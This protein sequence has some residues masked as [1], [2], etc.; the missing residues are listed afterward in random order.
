MPDHALAA[1]LPAHEL[2]ALDGLAPGDRKLRN[3]RRIIDPADLQARIAG[4]W[5]ETGEATAFRAR[6]LETIRE[7]LTD[8]RAEIRSRF[9]QRNDGADAVLAG[10]YLIDTIVR[11]LHEA[12]TARMYNAPNPTSGEQI[13]LIAI[14]GLRP[15]RNC[16]AFRHRPVV[17]ASLQ[18]HAARRTGRR[19]D[20][21]PA[22]GS[23]PEGRACDAFDRRMPAARAGRHDDPDVGARGPLS[24]RRA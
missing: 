3:R 11:A 15:G 9:M 23:S 10:A 12:V 18:G 14:G 2:P 7:A 5:T 1:R 19:G 13:C 17:P 22:L 24:V 8:G 20:P 6:L 4:L 21:V 16:A